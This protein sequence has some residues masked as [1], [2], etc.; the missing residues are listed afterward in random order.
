MSTQTTSRPKTTRQQ[1]AETLT[2]LADAQDERDEAN[3]QRDR[4]LE[5][6]QT[7]HREEHEGA[8]RFCTR[9]V[10]R[11]ADEALEGASRLMG[12]ESLL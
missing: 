12:S 5:L 1:L 2:D 7:L 8:L 6:V 3:R 11:A 4:V 10:C 9:E